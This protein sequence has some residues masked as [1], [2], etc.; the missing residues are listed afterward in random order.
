MLYQVI[1]KTLA[2]FGWIAILGAVASFGCYE[3]DKREKKGRSTK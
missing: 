3:M 2:E 1:M